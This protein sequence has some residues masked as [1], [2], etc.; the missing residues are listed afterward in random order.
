MP[1]ELTINEELQIIEIRSQGEVRLEDAAESMKKAI[2][3][4]EEI[5]INRLLIDTA[6]LTK[7]PSTVSVFN[8]FS[9]V[10][11]DLFFAIIVKEESFSGEMLSFG[12]TVA[13]N[14]GKNVKVFTNREVALEWLL[15]QK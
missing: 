5:G 8:F 4:H 11:D 7:L 3:I 10:S 6:E 1:D 13:V 15:N 14:R 9:Q 2:R 12:E